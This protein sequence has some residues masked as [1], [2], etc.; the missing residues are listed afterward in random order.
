M[1]MQ[2]MHDGEDDMDRFQFQGTGIVLLVI[3]LV[4]F[5]TGC[6]PPKDMGRSLS[7]F[8]GKSGAEGDIPVPELKTEAQLLALRSKL[9]RTLGRIKPANTIEKT[10]SRMHLR[11][12]EFIVENWGIRRE[13]LAEILKIVVK[14]TQT[15]RNASCTQMLAGCFGQT[16]EN[17]E[18]F[19]DDMFDM[20]QK[21]VPTGTRSK[22][23]MHRLVI[24]SLKP[25][26]IPLSAQGASSS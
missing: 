23:S 17:V 4:G 6:L 8:S 2:R 11:L 16:G 20:E 13:Q 5:S 10:K 24:G 12:E 21:A 22:K 14:S 9:G 3:S 26:A 15:C 7:Q 19:L 25:T 1:G 18:S